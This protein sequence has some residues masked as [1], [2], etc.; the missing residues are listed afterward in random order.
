MITK[1]KFIDSVAT[2]NK[3]YGNFAST[4]KLHFLC[5]ASFSTHGGDK[6]CVV[7]LVSAPE[8]NSGCLLF[9]PATERKGLHHTV[10]LE[11]ELYQPRDL[12]LR[13]F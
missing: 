8:Q 10:A 3:S 12:G 4:L 13:L 2:I 6:S 9:I 11:A 7:Y 1:K 5:V